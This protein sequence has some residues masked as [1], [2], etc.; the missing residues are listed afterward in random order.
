ML[1][2]Y[3]I[4]SN[5]LINLCILMTE[6]QLLN[7]CDQIACHSRQL[8]YAKHHI[9]TEWMHSS[10]L[11]CVAL[12]L[13][14]PLDFYWQQLS[15][16]PFLCWWLWSEICPATT[17]SWLIQSMQEWVHDVK[18]WMTHKRLKL[19]YDKMEALILLAP[20]ISNST[21]NSTVHFY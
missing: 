4:F 13:D 17:A 1:S 14:Y 6:S 10:G 18:L 20:R 15:P 21:G 16:S 5:M 11:A 19:N 3:C 8:H 7:I 2:A 9:K 12:S